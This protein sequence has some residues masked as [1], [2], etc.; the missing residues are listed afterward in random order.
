MYGAKYH[1]TI[2]LFCYRF[3]FAQLLDGSIPLVTW[4]ESSHI[5]SAA[6]SL[7]WLAADTQ[8]LTFDTTWTRTLFRLMQMQHGYFTTQFLE[9][10]LGI[11]RSFSHQKEIYCNASTV[12]RKPRLWKK[13]RRAVSWTDMT[14]GLNPTWTF[15]GKGIDLSYVYCCMLLCS[16][17]HVRHL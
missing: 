13:G 14:I 10:A 15:C 6:L 8:F 2:P 1:D 16:T 3:L 5:T 4:T 11:V 12:L 17:V 7:R 9:R